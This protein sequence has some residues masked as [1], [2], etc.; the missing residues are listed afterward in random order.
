MTRPISCA[1]SA[2]ALLVRAP[3]TALLAACPAKSSQRST[4]RPS[5]SGSLHLSLMF[6]DHGG[7]P[8][9]SLE[10]NRPDH[11]TA[12]PVE[13]SVF[14]TLY[15]LRASLPVQGEIQ[16]IEFKGALRQPHLEV[17][18]DRQSLRWDVRNSLAP[19]LLQ[20]TTR[21]VVHQEEG[22]EEWILHNGRQMG[23]PCTPNFIRALASLVQRLGQPHAVG[24]RSVSGFAEVMYFRTAQGAAIY[25]I[26]APDQPEEIHSLA[27]PGWYEDTARS[28]NLM[29]RHDRAR[30]AIDLYEVAG[31]H[32]V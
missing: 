1:P 10:L 6:A 26:A 24:I 15:S 8:E 14:Q 19:H 28:L 23:G 11:A 31:R 27:T 29:A 2:P 25:D 32:T 22:T 4:G 7:P 12:K 20:A 13:V 18:T 30:H 17:T 9:L 5:R 21:Q 3:M 16:R